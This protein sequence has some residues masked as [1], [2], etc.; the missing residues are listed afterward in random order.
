MTSATGVGFGRVNLIGEHT[1]YNLGLA[2]PM[3]LPLRVT[4]QASLRSDFRVAV[5]RA[6]RVSPRVAL[7]QSDIVVQ[8]GAP[9]VAGNWRGGC[10]RVK[11]R[12]FQRGRR[13]MQAAACI[14]EA[15]LDIHVQFMNI[16]AA[17]G[18]GAGLGRMF[19]RM[20]GNAAEL[21]GYPSHPDCGSAPAP[22]RSSAQDGMT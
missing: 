10:L 16:P 14:S 22:Q 20:R 12:A 21:S 1:D 13:S 6:P 15:Q 8:K 4:V 11:R 19:P 17:D 18:A 3:T 7:V 9:V 5:R 2:L